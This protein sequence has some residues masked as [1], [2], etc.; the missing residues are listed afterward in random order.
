M[1]DKLDTIIGW[2]AFFIIMTIVGIFV[3]LAVEI[4]FNLL[5]FAIG[6]VL[7]ALQGVVI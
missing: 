3:A 4:V 6:A 7:T 5:I 2:A 1:K